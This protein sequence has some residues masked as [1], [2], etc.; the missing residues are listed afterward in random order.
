M[1]QPV[2]LGVQLTGGSYRLALAPNVGTLAV[3]A[4]PAQRTFSSMGTWCHVI[5]HGGAADAADQVRA[6]IDRLDRVWTRFDPSSELCALN[7]AA[8]RWFDVSPDTLRLAQH[9]LLGWRRTAGA[10]DPFLA[11]RMAQVGY[12]RDFAA[13]RPVAAPAA[14]KAPPG[15]SRG[16]R[17]PMAV[18]PR[19]RR[20][21]VD[22]GAALDSGGIGKGLAA[23]VAASAALRR[24]VRSVLVNVGGDLR[25][26]GDTPEGGWQVSLDD[27]WE[28]GSASG[29][30]IRLQTGAVATSSTL[31][32]RWLYADGTQGH[33]LLDPRTGL[34]LA[35]RYAAVSVIARQ[36]WL[37]EVLT[38]VVFLWPPTRVAHMLRRHQAAAIVTAADG[39][40]RRLG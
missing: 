24:G 5:T 20:V 39:T 6:D 33:H 10:F 2:E 12:D 9:A 38:K 32:R 40:R 35:A 21:R 31:R 34:P 23:D 37:A 3:A 29:W 14:L 25:C 1:W 17:A 19:R 4:A 15:R 36:G 22:R 13:L 18:D 8:G 11:D 28:P 16:C 7:A 30:S 27:A 26:A